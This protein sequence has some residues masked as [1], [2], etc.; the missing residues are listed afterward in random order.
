MRVLVIGGNRFFGR[1]LIKEL[2]ADKC[3]V[4]L[5]NRGNAD[6]GFGEKVTRLRA[7]RK[8][9]SALKSAIAGQTWD[10]IFDQICYSAKEARDAVAIFDGRTKRYVVTSTESVYDYG[11]DQPEENFRPEKFEFSKDVFQEESYQ[12]AKR[13][14]EA[15]FIRNANFEVAIPRPSLVVGVDDYTGRL[16]WHIDRIKNLK[17]MYFPNVNVRT[18]FIKSDQAGNALKIIG[19]SKATG[20]VNCTTR[21]TIELGELIRIC[22]RATGKQAIF[23]ENEEGD[24]HS[25][26]GGEKTKSMNTARLYKLGFAAS[27][28]ETWMGALV[29][30]LSSSPV[31]FTP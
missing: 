14:M 6:D 16:Q 7:D 8:V 3:E 18:D 5:L 25:P 9:F 19:M 15:T 10:L 30:E 13:Q 23:A 24:N 17:P 21:G 4:T 31:P 2:L 29:T 12:T 26:Y 20:P 1:H 22:E 27:A 28:S 11:F